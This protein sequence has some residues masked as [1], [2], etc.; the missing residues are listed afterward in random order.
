MTPRWLIIIFGLLLLPALL[1]NLGIMVFI[2]DEAI[3]A[4]VAQEM[5]WSGDYL[6]PTMHGDPYLNKPPLWNWILTLSFWL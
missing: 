5:I 1:W 4:L 6:V 3:R 2:D